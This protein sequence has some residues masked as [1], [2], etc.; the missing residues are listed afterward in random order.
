MN[1]TA[2]WLLLG[3]GGIAVIALGSYAT[4]LW[5][6]VK[7]REALKNDE[8]R[9]ANDN[10]LQSLELI[11]TAMLNEQV[12][13]IEGSL[14]CKVLLEIIEPA[15]VARSSFQ[16]FAEVHQRTSHL[17]THSA[18]R[19]LS[20]RERMREDRERL[21]VEDELR[22]SILEAAHAVLDFKQRWPSSLN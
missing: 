20:P 19:E 18:R 2:A 11:A 1:E 3:V 17:H 10:C 4:V 12:D 15:L 21:A 22:D 14:R 5:R 16:V 6:E 9:R 13:P 8:I 7:R